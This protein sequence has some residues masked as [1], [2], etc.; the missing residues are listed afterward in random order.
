MN[1][2]TTNQNGIG[3]NTRKSSIEFSNK[4]AKTRREKENN[5]NTEY[6]NSVTN[7]QNNPCEETMN[8][9]KSSKTNLNDFMKTK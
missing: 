9:W 3:L 2:P 1:C 7:F 5:L 6:Q 8:R 4:V